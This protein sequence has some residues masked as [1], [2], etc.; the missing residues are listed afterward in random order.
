M[1]LWPLP[2]TSHFLLHHRSV[3][4]ATWLCKCLPSCCLSFLFQFTLSIHCFVSPRKVWSVTRFLHRYWMQR[5]QSVEIFNETTFPAKLSTCSS[6]FICRFIVN[7][8]FFYTLASLW[9]NFP[10][11]LHEE[12]IYMLLLLSLNDPTFSITKLT[13][14]LSWS[15]KGGRET[16]S[17]AAERITNRNLVKLQR[18]MIFVLKG[19]LIRLEHASM[20]SATVECLLSHFRTWVASELLVLC[21]ARQVSSITREFIYMP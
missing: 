16:S 13:L 21:A 10:L 15:A 7:T 8:N 12:I 17:D 4:H 20:L 2:W 11:L 6:F 18:L 3:W 5:T 19:F 1:P 14:D 9:E